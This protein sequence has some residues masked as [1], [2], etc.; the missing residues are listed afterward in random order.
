MKV[1]KS[2]ILR[3]EPNNMRRKCPK[4]TI[5]AQWL[6][7]WPQCVTTKFSLLYKRIDFETLSFPLKMSKGLIFHRLSCAMQK[8]PFDYKCFQLHGAVNKSRLNS[9]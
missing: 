9:H 5:S 3:Y 6:D 8:V 4:L 7:H 1:L 2:S